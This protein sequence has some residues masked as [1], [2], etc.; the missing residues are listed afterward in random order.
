MN[1]NSCIGMKSKK[2]NIHYSPPH[3]IVRR[4]FVLP[5]KKIRKY[6]SKSFRLI[7]SIFTS[8][9]FATRNSSNNF[10]PPVI[11]FFVFLL[12][13]WTLEYGIVTNNLRL[14]QRPLYLLNYKRRYSFFILIHMKW[15][16]FRGAL[17]Q[18]E[19]IWYNPVPSSQI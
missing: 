10:T 9:L 11:T 19:V 8:T 13:T 7:S 4:F 12:S 2:T 3:I 5:K 15:I 1:E 6:L 18:P 14:P 16:K 17:R